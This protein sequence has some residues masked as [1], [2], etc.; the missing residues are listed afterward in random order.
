M[1][2]TVIKPFVFQ[3]PDQTK[4]EFAVGVHD[5]VDDATAEH[6]YVRAH[7]APEEPKTQEAKGAGEK[8][9]SGRKPGDNPPPAK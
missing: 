5:D 2:I 8:K 6:W 1:S 4:R 9:N 3:L 7:C